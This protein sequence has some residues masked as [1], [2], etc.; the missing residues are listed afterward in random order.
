V[1]LKLAG[2]GEE[3]AVI[4]SATKISKGV[5]EMTIVDT[6][7][8][9]HE[10]TQNVNDIRNIRTSYVKIDKAT[11]KVMIASGIL[12]RDTICGMKTSKAP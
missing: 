4:D 9:G 10:L 12:K 1:E 2:T 11:D 7:V 8:S 6:G 3:Q 5:K